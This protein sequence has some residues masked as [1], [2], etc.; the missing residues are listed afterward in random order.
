MPACWS[1]T[2]G[3]G[4]ARGRDRGRWRV[5][6]QLEARARAGNGHLSYLILD[7]RHVAGS[8]LGVPGQVAQ[9]LTPRAYIFTDRPAYRPGQKVSIR[10]VVREVTNGQYANVP[11]SVYRL[12]VADSRGR[13]I[14]ARSV[15]LSDFGTFHESLELDSAAPLGT[16]RVRVYQPGKSEFAGD[17]EVGAYQLQPIDLTFDLKKTV[18]YR[19]DKVEGDLV[20]RYQYG[21]PLASRPIE[22]N[23]PDGRILHGTT[24]ATGKYHFEFPTEGF[25]EEQ[26][27]ALAG[28]LP[29]DNVAAAARVMLAI[30]GFG[31]TLS[32]ARDVYLDGESF[33]LQVVTTDPLGE[34]TGQSLS[35]ALV[36]LVTTQGRVTER[37][38]ERKPL[39]TDAKTGRGSL[40]FRVDDTQGGRYVI[41]VAGTDR[42]NN[43]IVADHVLTISGQKDETKLRLLADRQR[44][45]VGEEATVNLHSR[46]RAGAAMLA[47]EADRILSY[48]I[49]TLKEGDNPIAWA[50][51]GPQ[52]PNFTLTST[53]CGRTNA[54]RRGLTSR[55]SATCA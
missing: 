53:R 41:R 54:T 47:W 40:T 31:M 13:M 52:F 3:A 6:A 25:S 38:T 1:P 34:P 9:G 43:P 32:T 23:L 42:F 11:K 30:H 35:A 18:V 44:F 12:E 22:V 14:I 36:K 8:G 2:V 28:R 33:P 48:K 10:G 51:D 27:L 50:I 29:Q 55:S 49:V 21:A 15:R 46:G 37:E 26:R 16:Y 20:A 5:A 17:F 7:G 24:D 4:R 45:K 39:S 19:G